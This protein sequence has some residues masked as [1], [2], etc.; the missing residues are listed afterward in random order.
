MSVKKP[1]KFFFIVLLLALPA[2]LLG[3][4]SGC[5]NSAPDGEAILSAYGRAL[6]NEDLHA[7]EQAMYFE[8]SVQREKVLA[9]YRQ[10]F[11]HIDQFKTQFYHVLTKQI[12]Q[13]QATATFDLKSSWL[14]KKDQ[15]GLTVS[16]RR[17]GGKYHLRF[18]EIAG[19]KSHV[20]SHRD[21]DDFRPA[22][23][24]E[25]LLLTDILHHYGEC[26][27]H[28]DLQS[29][30]SLVYDDRISSGDIDEYYRNFF[31]HVDKIDWQPDKVVGWFSGDAGIITFD[32]HS[33][34]YHKLEKQQ[35]SAT[36][37]RLDD[38]WKL[39]V[40]MTEK[41]NNSTF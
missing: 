28:H 2:I 10:R 36:L 3:T 13:D 4:I 35:M 27:Q 1:W 20:L 22:T 18:S 19:I 14:Q 9:N 26:L 21:G 17:T 32:L 39:A 16:F 31:N 33:N 30:V 7:L 41:N 25:T 12:N 23:P 24:Q 37:R 5:T 38:R 11:A 15:E 8:T 6:E 34:W 29:I 40:G